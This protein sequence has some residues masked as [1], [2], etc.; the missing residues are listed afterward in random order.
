MIWRMAVYLDVHRGGCSQRGHFEIFVDLTANISGNGSKGGA[1]LEVLGFGFETMPYESDLYCF[2]KVVTLMPKFDIF[3]RLR[4][5]G[6]SSGL[7]ILAVG[8]G[9]SQTGHFEVLVDLKASP[10]GN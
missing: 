3:G 7:G 1:C 8:G 4:V 9:Y 10:F 6:S 2:W 5:L